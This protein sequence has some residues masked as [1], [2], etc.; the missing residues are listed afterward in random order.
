MSIRSLQG[1]ININPLKIQEAFRM[2]RE[3]GFKIV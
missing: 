2:G 1:R 3:L